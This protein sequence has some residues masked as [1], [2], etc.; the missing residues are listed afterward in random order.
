MHIDSEDLIG[1]IDASL[2]ADYTAV[3]RIGNRIG[4]A[5]AAEDLEVGKR[6][7]SSLR[8]SGVPLR[9]SGQM[10]TLP[11]DSKSR[12]P[13]LEEQVW[14]STPLF[15]DDAAN[16]AVS[17]FLA[18]VQHAERLRRKGITTKF[19]ALLSGPPGTGKSLLAGHL[20]ARLELPLYVVR[21]DSLISSLLGDTAK[22]I[23]SVFDFAAARP[24]ALFLDELDAVAKSR[25]DSR[26]LGELRRV[27]NTVLQ[28]LDALD[29]K[30]VLIGATNHP[31]LLDSAVWRRFPYRITLSNPGAD[32]RAD[33]WRYFLADDAP[34]AA[35]VDVLTQLSS[36]LTGCDIENHALA[37]RRRAILDE[38]PLDF[39]ALLW[40]VHA[41]VDPGA[42]DSTADTLGRRKV[43]AT[44]LVRE[45]GLTSVD[46][47][48]ML[49]VSRQ[50]VHN[51][52]RE[53]KGVQSE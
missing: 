22:N 35:A 50:T 6:I 48:R 47:A 39:L 42:S 28:A 53:G 51:Y 8:R 43:L 9:A 7:L 12:L 52:L 32:V 34:D 1:L 26:D 30:A 31:Q 5:A 19:N 16:G 36:R 40:S 38:R 17:N 37:A 15:L 14:P 24:C 33:M 41:T 49:G 13:L 23:R 25:D 3:R 21:L 4:K 10:E 11:V 20:A 45:L 46:A 44:T 18:D 2:R 27:V 29:D